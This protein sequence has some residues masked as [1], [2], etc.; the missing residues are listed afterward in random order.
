MGFRGR[1]AR[2]GAAFGLGVRQGR[3][4]RHGLGAGL[5]ATLCS[6]TAALATEGATTYYLQGANVPAGGLMPPPGVYFDETTY[7][8]SGKFKAG[9]TTQ[10]GGN[11]VLDVRL[12]AWANFPTALWVTPVEILG[13]NLALSATAPFGEPAIRAAAILDGPLINQAFGRPI[14][15]SAR[16]A[17]VNFADPFATASIGWHNGNWH[18]KVGAAVNIP[19]GDYRPGKLSNIAFHRWIGDFTFGVTYLDP[20]LGLDISTVAGFLVNGANPVTDYRSGNEFHIDGS[21]SKNLTKQ[22]SVGILASYYE[23]V[24]ADSGAGNLVGPFKGRST[25]VGGTIGY[26]FNL[27]DLP[28]STRV[29]LMREIEVENRP[30][31]T[32]GWVQVT[33]PL[34]T[35]PAQQ[36]SARMVVR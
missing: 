7:F 23:Q 15:F 9:R 36:P 16:D 8:Y 19:V 22:L 24:S 6:A 21:I 29:K 5:I 4:G 2:L 1:L 13:G 20:T 34:W 12:N 3:K 32:L 28:V 17:V 11:Q 25:A 30:R 31:G 33:I 18:W 26:T 35:P 27:G 10:L 14:G